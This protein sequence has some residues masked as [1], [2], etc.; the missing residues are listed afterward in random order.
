MA[1]AR[2]TVVDAFKIE[3]KRVAAPY[4]GALRS[5]FEKKH[6]GKIDKD[7]LPTKMIKTEK[8]VV[9]VVLALM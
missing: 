7:G 3:Q 4:R 9:E 2:N 5:K 1:A 6:P 8:G